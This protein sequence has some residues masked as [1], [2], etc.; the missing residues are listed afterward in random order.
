[1]SPQLQVAS[2][3]GGM[4]FPGSFLPPQM[5]LRMGVLLGEDVEDRRLPGGTGVGA[6]SSKVDGVTS[7]PTGNS[8]PAGWAS[9]DGPSPLTTRLSGLARWWGWTVEMPS[10]RGS[11]R[12]DGQASLPGL[13]GRLPQTQVVTLS[14]YRV[15]NHADVVDPG[16]TDRPE[17]LDHLV[18]R[19]RCRA[20][21]YH[22][23]VRAWWEQAM[24]VR[25]RDN[26]KMNSSG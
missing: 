13:M 19:L 21:A 2:P 9:A 16:G 17:R 11:G 10:E 3:A 7:H 14:G 1:M 26:D 25:R 5:H 4:V 6:E 24:G 12:A 22:P 23:Q 15:E 8:P 20:P 18:L